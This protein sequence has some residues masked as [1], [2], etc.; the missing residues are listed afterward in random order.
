MSLKD[1]E[2][3]GSLDSA[4]KQIYI[5]FRE[6]QAIKILKM[7]KKLFKDHIAVAFSGG[8]DSLAVLHLAYEVLGDVPVIFNNTTV[9]FP[10]TIKYVRYIAKEWDLNLIITKP[11]KPFLSEVKHRGWATHEHR[12]CCTPYKKDPARKFMMDNEIIA[13]ITGTIR[14]ESIYRRSLKPFKFYKHDQNIVRIHP[15]YDW[16]QQEVWEYIKGKKLPYN[17]LYDMGYRRIGCWCCPLNGISH[18]KRL[19]KTHPKTFSFL[20]KFKPTHQAILKL[21]NHWYVR[22]R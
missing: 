10:E 15:I 18:Y 3:L 7:A 12:W 9:E 14:T 21:Q 2:L 5:Q 20:T 17:P 4:N 6:E 1:V 16:N 11:K 13:E 22:G 19:C 8:K